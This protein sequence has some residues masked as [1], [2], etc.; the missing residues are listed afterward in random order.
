MSNTSTS[1]VCSPISEQGFVS[2]ISGRPIHPAAPGRVLDQGNFPA[3]TRTIVDIWGEVPEGPWDASTG[4]P[5]LSQQGTPASEDTVDRNAVAVEAETLLPP[6]PRDLF[7]AETIDPPTN[8]HAPHATHATPPRRQSLHRQLLN[9]QQRLASLQTSAMAGSRSSTA[10]S[11]AAESIKP[12]PTITMSTLTGA[13]KLANR[14]DYHNWQKFMWLTLLNLGCRYLMPDGAYDTRSKVPAALLDIWEQNQQQATLLMTYSFSNELTVAFTKEDTVSKVFARA[15]ADFLDEGVSS[16][17]KIYKDWET[18]SLSDDGVRALAMK[19]VAIQERFIAVG[20]QHAAPNSHLMLKLISCLDDRFNAWRATFWQNNAKSKTVPDFETVQGLLEAEEAGVSTS[21]TN[22]PTAFLANNNR[23][24][25]STNTPLDRG[26]R[27]G[28]RPPKFCKTCSK[29]GH[30][31]E[32]CWETRPDL[33]K[34]YHLRKLRQLQ[35]QPAPSPSAAAML[36]IPG[37]HEMQ[38]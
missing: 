16:L 8:T 37:R 12:L 23:K 33:R 26:Q 31:T 11:A 25:S 19:I 29:S 36:A 2:R 13:P 20:P 10:A 28:G 3:M 6:S 30:I 34:E 24:R 4:S 15:K 18:L 35:E 27:Q 1:T 32:D 14:A 22:S 21:S 5:F 7:G 17:Q 38:L 9:Q